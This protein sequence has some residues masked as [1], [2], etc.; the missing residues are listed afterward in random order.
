MT[1]GD[2]VK[3]ARLRERILSGEAQRVRENAHLSRGDIAR[4]LEVDPSAVTRYELG[5]RLPRAGVAL[6][7]S[8][9]LDGLEVAKK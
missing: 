6:R 5:Q 7:Y 8:A 1:T 4:E 2:A 9:L 3:V